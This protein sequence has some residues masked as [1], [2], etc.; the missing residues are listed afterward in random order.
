MKTYNIMLVSVTGILLS[1]LAT[2]QA[3]LSI[4]NGDFQ[5]QPASGNSNAVTSWFESSTTFNF[6]DYVLNDSSVGGDTALLFES[7]GGFIYQS[8]G[9]LDMTDIAAGSFKISGTAVKRAGRAYADDVTI[10]AFSGTFASAADGTPLTG[11]SSL[12]SFVIDNSVFAGIPQG[13]FAE[14]AFS[15]S[16]FDVSSLSAGTE[17][18]L[19]IGSNKGV[20]GSIAPGVDDLSVALIPEPT[21]PTLLGVFGI[22]FFL[23]R[24]RK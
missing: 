13:T 6:A 1:C 21:V 15:S 11:V 10:E 19:R 16:A 12:G 18:W 2:T 4:T 20:G 7:S 23:N 22:M 14:S 24:R 9:T 5:A 17:I 8:L 3:A